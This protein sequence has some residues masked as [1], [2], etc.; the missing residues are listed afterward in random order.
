MVDAERLRRLLQRVADDLSRLEPYVGLDPDEL[1]DDEIVMDRIKYR[2]VTAIEGCID[3]AHHVCSSEGWGPPDTNADAMRVLARHQILAPDLGATMA[4]AVAFR[5]VL[6]HGYATVDDRR[7]VAHLTHVT[8][9]R[10]YLAA[11]AAL[12]GDG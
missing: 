2:F 6:V 12:P 8:D 10:R 1:T 9:L 7:V 4:D 5:N 11:M 3:A